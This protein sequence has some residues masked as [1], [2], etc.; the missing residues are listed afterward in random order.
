[1]RFSP[2]LMENDV[3]IKKITPVLQSFDEGLSSFLD[4][5]TDETDNIPNIMPGLEKL[6][7]KLFKEAVVLENEGKLSSNIPVNH[8]RSASMWC[9]IAPYGKQKTLIIENADNMKDEASNSLLKLLEEPPGLVNIVLTVKRRERILPT[10]LSRLRP[11]RFF[12]RNTENEKKVIRLVFKDT[13]NNEDD[14]KDNIKDNINKRSSLITEYLESFMPQNYDKMHSLAAWFLVSIARI[15]YFSDKIKG[16][17]TAS[18]FYEALGKHYA[19]I[20]ESLNIERA[21]RNA[22]IIKTILLQTKNFENDSFPRFM[23]ICLDMTGDIIR[24]EK[25]PQFNV[26]YDIFKKHINEAITAVDVLNV[27]TNIAMEALLYNLK[28]SKKDGYYG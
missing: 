28:N 16:A 27:D 26:Y 1:M 21:A 9:R 24:L 17:G 14:I 4:Y 15:G 2:I 20:A 13:V 8:V 23:K 7:E 19:S 10:I 6:C 25:Y 12:K 5:N 18:A 3:K 11:Y 22:V